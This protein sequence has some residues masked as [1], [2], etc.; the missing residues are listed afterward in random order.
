MVQALTKSG[1]GPRFDAA[2]RGAGAGF[3]FWDASI[4][5]LGSDKPV[6]VGLACLSFLLLGC[7]RT[8]APSPRNREKHGSVLGLAFSRY[9]LALLGIFPIFGFA[10]HDAFSIIIIIIIPS[11]REGQRGPDFQSSHC[12]IVTWSPMGTN[13]RAQH[14][15]QPSAY[16]RF[17]EQD[18]PCRLTNTGT[19]QRSA[20]ASLKKPKRPA[21]R[22]CCSRWRGRGASWHTRVSRFRTNRR[23][24]ARRRR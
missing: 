2:E 5:A 6:P 23:L 3:C 18:T 13:V 1:F 9:S 21:T 8:H 11:T 22:R 24:A 12:I 20:Y 15:F 16:A 7:F 17:A 10:L 19:T 14:P 4:R